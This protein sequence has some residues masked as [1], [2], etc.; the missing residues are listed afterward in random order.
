R[1]REQ[2]FQNRAFQQVVG[3]FGVDGHDFAN[4]TCSGLTP[5]PMKRAGHCRSHGTA[6]NSLTN[7]RGLGVFIDRKLGASSR[8][9]AVTWKAWMTLVG[10]SRRACTVFRSS[11]LGVPFCNFG[12]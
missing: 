8:F 11:K 9:C 12:P 4:I 5:M 2:R 6:S 10:N 3:G 1:Q 7:K